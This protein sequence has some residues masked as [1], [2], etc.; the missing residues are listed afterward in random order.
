M[1]DALI[2][3]WR[4]I[5][6]G[7]PRIDCTAFYDTHDELPTSL[8]RHQLALVGGSEQR[9]KWAVSECP[10]G[11]CHRIAVPLISRR[12]PVWHVSL[13]DHRRPSLFPSIDSNDGP[14]C[15]FLLRNGRIE[16]APDRR[17][18]RRGAPL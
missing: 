5:V 2:D 3:G 17:R 16:W 18:G 1:R 13:D 11:T 6:P 8:P 4:R 12:Q 14:R 15:H 9:P 10:C 7:R